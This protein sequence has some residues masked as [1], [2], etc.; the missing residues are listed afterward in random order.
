MADCTGREEGVSVTSSVQ[1]MIMRVSG[2][3]AL[4]SA[5]MCLRITVRDGKV[6]SSVLVADLGR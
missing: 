2:Y 6:I 1:S 4:N 5:G 3:L